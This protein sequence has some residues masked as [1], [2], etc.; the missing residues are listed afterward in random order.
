MD[1][2]LEAKGTASARVLHRG[3]LGTFQEQRGGQ[4]SSRELSTREGEGDEG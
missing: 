1:R 3:S 4:R 2:G